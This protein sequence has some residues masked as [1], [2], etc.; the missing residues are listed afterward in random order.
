L[1]CW[2]DFVQQ[3]DA[4]K[5]SNTN[6]IFSDEAMSN[7]IGRTWQYR[8]DIPYP[9]KALKLALRGWDVR[10]LMVHRPLYD[11]I[12]SVYTDQYKV[13]K[14]SNKRRLK[15]WHG[16]G[17]CIDQGGKS[18]PRPFDLKPRNDTKITMA[19][20]LRENQTL[21]PTP[22]RMYELIRDQQQQQGSGLFA[23][24]LLVDMENNVKKVGGDD[25]DF[26]D[27]IVCRSVPGLESTCKALRQKHQQQLRTKKNELQRHH[28]PSLP[29]HYD[30]VAVEACQGGLID[31]RL[32]SREDLRDAIQ[33]RQEEELG[34]GP[35]DLPMDCLTLPPGIGY[36][37]ILNISMKHEERLR[38]RGKGSKEWNR[39]RE[40]L[41]KKGFWK[42][43]KKGKK[44]CSVNTTILL[45][46]EGWKSFL[47]KL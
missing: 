40:E 32:V 9:W 29:L 11:Y 14:H 47:S 45:E 20:L 18:I 44:Y 30:F 41:H 22:A 3:L 38:G 36:T 21:F 35:N 4:Y 34:L 28:N 16:G 12:P 19:T 6:I 37:T 7:R 26:I 39:E 24:I 33:R 2:E 13:P 1:Q 15:L 5:D 42:A 8:P 25:A 31:G 43:V 17:Q 10:V 46:D 27:E 23:E